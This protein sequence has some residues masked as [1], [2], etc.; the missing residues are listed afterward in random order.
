[1]RESDVREESGGVPVNNAGDGRID[2]IGVGPRG[3]PGVSVTKKKTKR[4][5]RDILSTARLQGETSRGRSQ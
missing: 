2:G 3:E 4:R 1:M 5:L